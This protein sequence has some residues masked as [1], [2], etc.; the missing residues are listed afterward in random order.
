LDSI[1]SGMSVYRIERC[2]QSGF[3]GQ[4]V[5]IDCHQY[6]AW[7]NPGCRCWTIWNHGYHARPTVK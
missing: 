7:S 3:G 5:A 4:G 1:G 6:V 2:G